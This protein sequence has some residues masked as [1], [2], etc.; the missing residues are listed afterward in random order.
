M[1]KVKVVCTTNDV[2][3]IAI[4][5]AMIN[6]VRTREELTAA[7]NVCNECEGCKEHIDYILGSICG[8]KHVALQAVVDVVKNGATT[9]EEVGE[10]TG[11]GTGEGC[12]RCKALIQNVIDL[13]R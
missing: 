7:V 1:A 12:G 6:G 13:G 4:R 11:A 9:V 2:E 5:R 10:L 8:C 3:Y